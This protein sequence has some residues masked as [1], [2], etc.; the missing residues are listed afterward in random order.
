[1]T[2]AEKER[3]ARLNK[4][5]AAQSSQQQSKPEVQASA[6]PDKP[7]QGSSANVDRVDRSG[8]FSFLEM[9]KNIP[10]S[11]GQFATD[12]ATPFM[13]PV[14]TFNAVTDLGGGALDKATEYASNALPRDLVERLNR[15]QNEMVG[16]NTLGVESVFGVGQTPIAPEDMQYKNIDKFDAMTDFVG[17]RYG[18]AD[19]AKQTLMN[20]PIGLL[21]DASAVV[22]GGAALVPK[23]GKAGVIAN[24]VGQV[25]RAADP[26]NVAL[27][28]GK[29][30]G[31]GLL[32]DA[33]PNKMYQKSAKFSNAK[34][35][36]D[37]AVL[38]DTALK[39]D[40]P[41]TATGVGKLT[42]LKGELINRIDQIIDTATASG[43]EIPKGAVFK[44]L[45]ELRA[46]MGGVRLRGSKNKSAI[47][48]IAKEFDEHMKK[49]GKDT[50]TPRE[51]QQF[52]LDI[53]ADNK[54][55]Q[56]TL[57]GTRIGEKTEKAF[58]R[59]A[60]EL[61]EQQ[62]PSVAG[63]N[64]QLGELSEL[65]PGLQSAAN[66][67]EKRNPISIDSGINIAA[68]GA[69]AGPGGAV[70]GG[71]LSLL[72]YPNV[73]QNLARGLYKQKMMG[74]G[75]LLGGDPLL[76]GVSQGSFQAGRERNRTIPP[77]LR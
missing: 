70:A 3:Q 4:A 37:P 64:K 9:L 51:L 48:A 24:K 44:H 63:L 10:Q 29:V 7:P 43:V 56:K 18:S 65:E 46:D 61:L 16:N 58:A 32:S 40:L 34:N 57:Q 1:M 5:W 59:A 53:Y 22:S 21:A 68:G 41:P 27:N 66:R 42:M 75:G 69:G 15:A 39:Y 2:K 72:A 28:T 45:S 76:T 31:A 11:A 71:A 8:D 47:T 19:R 6:L 20:D 49:L 14:D 55:G 36:P 30:A 50:I 54:Y 26:V 12:V 52:K 73:Q 33:L 77:L 67:I 13:H 35:A 25:A 17:S 38:A 60:K 23:V 62:D 74:L